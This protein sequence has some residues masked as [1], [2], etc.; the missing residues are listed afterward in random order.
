MRTKTR[1]LP[2]N[3][4]RLVLKGFSNS[5]AEKRYRLGWPDEPPVAA[6]YREG[7]QCGGCS[8]F[9]R[10]DSDWGLCCASRGRHFTET[11][12]EHFTCPVHADEGWEAH[13]FGNGARLSTQRADTGR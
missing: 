2:G 9:A 13:S 6:L 12:F 11:V 4:N 1:P 7:R 10:F 8:F 5:D 3:R